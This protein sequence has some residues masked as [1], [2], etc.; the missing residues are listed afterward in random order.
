MEAVFAADT[1][2]QAEATENQKYLFERQTTSLH[3]SFQTQN[4][5]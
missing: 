4:K 1:A 3:D 2:K 5:Q